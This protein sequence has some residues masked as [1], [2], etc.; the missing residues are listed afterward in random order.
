[1]AK[2][3]CLCF[4]CV[5]LAFAQGH[6]ALFCTHPAQ[7]VA[8]SLCTLTLFQAK[9]VKWRILH[10]VLSVPGIQSLHP[11]FW[12]YL[13]TDTVFINLKVLFQTQ[14]YESRY[15]C[16][17]IS[18]KR[19][20]YCFLFSLLFPTDLQTEKGSEVAFL[21]PIQKLWLQTNSLTPQKP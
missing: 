18:I 16:F 5:S 4:L 12:V 11:F 2:R 9:A 13:H 17:L 20:I 6:P 19:D 15:E 21:C 10:S 7:N 8:V 3:E 1:M 14:Y